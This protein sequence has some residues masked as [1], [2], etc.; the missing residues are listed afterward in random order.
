MKRTSNVVSLIVFVVTCA[1]IGA[2]AE[3]KQA[4]RTVGHA[5]RDVAK[6]IGHASR[7]V[8]KEITRGTKRVI[9]EA[10]E[11]EDK[12]AVDVSSQSEHR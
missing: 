3:L 10:A 8:A 7:D 2:C 12:S 6:E 11:P 1:L 4:G 5:S 9:A